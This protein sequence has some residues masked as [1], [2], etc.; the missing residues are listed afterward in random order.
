MN[1]SEIHKNLSNISDEDILQTFS[2]VSVSSGIF[3]D[4]LYEGD[5]EMRTDEQIDKVIYS[6]LSELEK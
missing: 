2:Y 3:Y 4:G 5:R 6:V 1:S